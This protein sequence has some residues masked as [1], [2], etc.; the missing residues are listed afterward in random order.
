MGR[1]DGGSIY[2]IVWGAVV[3]LFPAALFRF[4]EMELLRYPQVWQ[5]VGIIVGVY[6][7]GYLIAATD[8]LRHQRRFLPHLRAIQQL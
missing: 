6:G 1:A 5:C 3:I 2:N 8:P 7:I 4:A